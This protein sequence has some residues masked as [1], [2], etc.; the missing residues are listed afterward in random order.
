MAGYAADVLGYEL[1]E[2]LVQIHRTGLP[3]V[4]TK[5]LER[6][7][8][9]LGLWPGGKAPAVQQPIVDLA[10]VLREVAVA[11]RQSIC[12]SGAAVRASRSCGRHDLAKRVQRLSKVGNQ[13]AHPDVGLAAEMQAI[14]ADV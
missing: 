4:A 6:A 5:R 10:V 13:H 8:V 12:N 9:E 11:T 1:C 14:G 2:V 3:S 7:A